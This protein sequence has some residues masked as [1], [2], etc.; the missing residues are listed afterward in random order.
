MGCIHPGSASWRQSPAALPTARARG[1][2]Y[3]GQ[4]VAEA[5]TA[6]AVLTEL[7]QGYDAGCALG[8]AAS[9]VS[10]DGGRDQGVKVLPGGQVYGHGS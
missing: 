7:A 8:E 3:L 10:L 6:A 2:T 4:V 5:V 1:S 9:V